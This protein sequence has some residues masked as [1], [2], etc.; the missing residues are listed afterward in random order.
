MSKEFHERR[1]NTL[2]WFLTTS[3]QNVV[4]ALMEDGSLLEVIRDDIKRLQERERFSIDENDVG[5]FE[6]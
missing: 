3:V 4:E 6:P 5:V 1:L 2:E